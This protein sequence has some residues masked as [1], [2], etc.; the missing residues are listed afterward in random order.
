M[1]CQR[2]IDKL[3]VANRLAKAD[4]K[5]PF[6]SP[7]PFYRIFKGHLRNAVEVWTERYWSFHWEAIS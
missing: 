5:R 4:A 7:K 1:P 2:D 6:H 3:K